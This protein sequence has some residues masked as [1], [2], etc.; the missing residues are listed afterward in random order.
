MIRALFW[1]CLSLGGCADES[2]TSISLSNSDDAA[3]NS[4]EAGAST[5]AARDTAPTSNIEPSLRDTGTAEVSDAGGVKV[6]ARVPVDTRE[7]SLETPED[8]AQTFYDLS[9]RVMNNVSTRRY[10]IAVTDFD[11]DGDFEAVFTGYGGL[12]EVWD[13]Q[14]NQLV[15]I[16]PESIQDPDRSAIG[17]TACDMDGDGAE[18]LY[19]LNVDRFGGLG[20]VSDR[21]SRRGDNTWLDVFEADANIAAVNRF[22]GRSVMCFDRDGDGDYGVFV[23]NYGGPMKLFEVGLD[24]TLTDVAPSLGMALTTGGRSLVNLPA[25]DGRMQLFA[26]NENGP[27]FFFTGNGARYQE[28]AATLGID[29]RFETVRGVAVL[30]AD[31]DG[32]FDL[33]YG[34]WNGPHRLFLNRGERFENVTPS[35]METPSRIRTVIAADFDNDGNE[36]LFWNNIGEP[37]RLFKSVNGTWSEIDI[38]AALEPDG[39]GTGAAV[40]DIDGDGRLELFVAHGESGAQPLSVFKWGNNANHYLRV[41]PLTKQGGPARGAVVTLRTNGRTQRRVIDSGSGYLCQMEPIAH[42]GLGETVYPITVDVIWPGGKRKSIE[43]VSSDQ[44]LSVPYP[45]GD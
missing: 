15:N 2:S 9:A 18:E 1:L 16:A 37:N 4:R 24:W 3:L 22:S 27:N 28:I 7:A 39:L 38:G 35:S 13:F 31:Q 8:N 14:N 36:E 23:A 41:R 25:T 43:A 5:T 6:D 42:F 12:K 44:T 11:Q 40:V 19:F 20:E 26:G 33:V 32:Q 30:D 17:V 45:E 21:L 29:D 10:G 34:N